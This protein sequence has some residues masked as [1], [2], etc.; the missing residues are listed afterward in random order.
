MSEEDV[1][2]YLRRWGLEPYEPTE[3]DDTE[4]DSASWPDPKPIDSLE[5]E[6]PT[7]IGLDDIDPDI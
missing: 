7:E 4:D 5:I 1:S 3:S 6:D 2:G